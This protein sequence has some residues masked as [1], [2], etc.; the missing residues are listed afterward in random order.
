[1]MGYDFPDGFSG[2][3]PQVEDPPKEEALHPGLNR[4]DKRHLLRICGGDVI[5]KW[6]REFDLDN[7]FTLRLNAPP[8]NKT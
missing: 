4:S 6:I 1:M 5:E 8:N 3:E 2:P 7:P